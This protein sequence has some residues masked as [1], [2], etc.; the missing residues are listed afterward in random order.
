MRASLA[1]SPPFSRGVS[2]A[3]V[4]PHQTATLSNVTHS[5]QPDRRIMEVLLS[6]DSSLG[7]SHPSHHCKSLQHGWELR[8][9]NLHASRSRRPH[10][11]VFARAGSRR[12]RN[13]LSWPNQRDIDSYQETRRHAWPLMPI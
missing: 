11:P 5:Q 7:G 3:A 9:K 10:F 6:M 8:K 4:M 2:A 1:A 13:L 12:W